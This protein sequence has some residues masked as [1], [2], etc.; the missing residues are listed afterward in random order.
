MSVSVPASQD[1]A[2]FLQAHFRGR[3]ARRQLSHMRLRL[4]ATDLPNVEGRMARLAGYKSDPYVVFKVQAAN[5]T[6]VAVKNGNFK[7]Q[8]VKNELSPE[9]P[10][11]CFTPPENIGNGSRENPLRIEI[12]DWNSWGPSTKMCEVLIPGGLEE[13]LAMSEGTQLP[14]ENAESKACGNLSFVRRPEV[15]RQATGPARH[16]RGFETLLKQGA[17]KGW[18]K[19]D[20]KALKVNIPKH[21]GK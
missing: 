13:L 6:F 11:F 9:F 16:M 2:I 4:K 20:K 17:K 18:K 19:A 15:F 12:W 8:R 3:Q 10:P 7:K 5:G 1:A 14:L 21:R